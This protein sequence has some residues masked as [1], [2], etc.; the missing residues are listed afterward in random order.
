MISALFA[1]VRGSERR[2]TIASLVCLVGCAALL[3]PLPSPGKLGWRPLLQDWC[4]VPVFAAVSIV[5]LLARCTRKRSFSRAV[6]GVFCFVIFL[7]VGTECL[8]VQTGRTPDFDDLLQDLVGTC[9]GILGV[10]I[11][12]VRRPALKA[13]FAVLTAGMILFSASHLLIRGWVSWHKAATFPLIEDFESPRSWSLW[14]LEHD[15][16]SRALRSL[17][18]TQPAGSALFL[19][20]EPRGLTSLHHDACGHD[21]SSGTALIL[22]CDSSLSAPVPLGI[23]IDSADDPARRVRIGATLTPGASEIRVPLPEST[24]LRAVGQLVL[25]IEDPGVAGLITLDN[26]RLSTER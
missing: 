17:S 9:I 18:T 5:L 19:E 11:F 2:W 26:I 14:F 25:F 16:E 12:A 24:V 6:P 15:G 23:R 7:A 22:E 20:V 8:Q 13:G 1:A 10:T 4:H 21:W 3:W